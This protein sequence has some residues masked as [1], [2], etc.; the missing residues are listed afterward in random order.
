MSLDDPFEALR[1]YAMQDRSPLADISRP[2]ER[3]PVFDT[4]TKTT[5][6]VAHPTTS[7]SIDESDVAL[8]ALATGY[9]VFDFLQ[10]SPL[11]DSLPPSSGIRSGTTS[12]FF[13]DHGLGA[14]CPRFESSRMSAR[15]SPLSNERPHG[16]TREFHFRLAAMSLGGER[17]TVRVPAGGDLDYIRFRE[18]LKRSLTDKGDECIWRGLEM[19]DGPRLW[20]IKEVDEVESS[21][22]SELMMDANSQFIKM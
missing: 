6:R 22:E 7:P 20:V 11:S 9:T 13:P 17:L 5:E 8:R 18:E 4:E 15:M 12:N 3:N 16:H 10:E 19:Q 2:T 1:A 21:T 14:D